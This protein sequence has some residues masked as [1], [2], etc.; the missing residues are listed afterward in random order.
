MTLLPKETKHLITAGSVMLATL[1]AYGALFFFIQEKMSETADLVLKKEDEGMRMVHIRAL[2]KS[3][4]ETASEREKISS[5]FV[6]KNEAVQFI[7]RIE[8]LGRRSNLSLSLQNVSVADKEKVFR[9]NANAEGRFE[10][11]MYFLELLPNLPYKISLEAANMRGKL[12]GAGPE[13]GRPGIWSGSFTIV[14]ESF[15]D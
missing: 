4:K 13:E 5:Y 3:L 8:E 7:E 11:M 12:E 1:F 14:L 15:V 2:E 10:D 6:R 9:L